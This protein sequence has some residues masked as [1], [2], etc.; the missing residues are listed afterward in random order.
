MGTV[1]LVGRTNIV[2]DDEL[3]AKTKELYGFET[4]RE[5]VDVALRRLVGSGSREGFRKLRGTGWEGDLEE[6]RQTRF[7]D[8]LC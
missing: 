5:V 3:V 1:R 6:M 2:I 4:T 8:W 7:P